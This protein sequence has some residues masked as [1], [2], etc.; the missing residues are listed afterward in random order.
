MN[1][2]IFYF[3]YLWPDYPPVFKEM[4]GKFLNFLNVFIKTSCLKQASLYAFIDNDLLP[5]CFH[6]PVSFCYLNQIKEV[7]CPDL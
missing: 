5:G 3:D 6:A 4:I 7:A 2:F 1:D